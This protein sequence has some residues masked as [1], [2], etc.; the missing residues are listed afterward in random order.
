MKHSLHISFLQ[1]HFRSHMPRYDISTA[2]LHRYSHHNWFYLPVSEEIS[3]LGVTIDR[4][5]TFESHI[6]A[7][8]KSCNYHLW[9]LQH[10]RHLLPFSTAQTLACSLILSPLDYCN[11]VLYGCSAYAIG[12]LQHVENYAACVVTQSNRCTCTITTATIVVA[13][14]SSAAAACLQDGTHHIQSHNYINSI[15]PQ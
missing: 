9:A 15:I 14:A 4:R 7:V 8:V 10:I 1:T 13:L 12:R 2:Q 5:L 11:A 6:S 3:S